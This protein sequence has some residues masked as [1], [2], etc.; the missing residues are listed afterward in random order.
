MIVCFSGTGNSKAVAERLAALLGDSLHFIPD[1]IPPC[2]D[3]KPV[4]WV[5]PIYSWDIPPIVRKFMLASG[6]AKGTEHFMVAT[7]GDDIGLAAQNWRAVCH[8]KGWIAKA[9][10]SVQMPNNYVCMKGFDTDDDS[11]VSKK[12]AAMPA[13]VEAVAEAIRSNGT[14]DNVV[15][16]SFAWMKTRIIAPYFHRFC[17]NPDD[18]NVNEQCISCGKCEKSCP[19]DNITLTDSRPVW[20]KECAFCLRCYHICPVHAIGYKKETD[21]KGQ[22]NELLN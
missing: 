13:R 16:G 20:G 4:I 6:F 22:Y 1:G 18:F 3:S 14:T 17:M 11:L 7:C 12:L 21:G 9:A 19:C 15:R 10:F 5:F 2:T 8:K